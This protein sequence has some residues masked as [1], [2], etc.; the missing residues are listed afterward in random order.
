LIVANTD[1]LQAVLRAYKGITNDA[2]DALRSSLLLNGD[3]G[4]RPFLEESPNADVEPSCSLGKP[5]AMSFR[6][7]AQRVSVMEQFDGRR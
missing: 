6:S 3:F 1:A 5:S 4:R 7:V 2:L